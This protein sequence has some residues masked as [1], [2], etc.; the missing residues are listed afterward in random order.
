MEEERQ[1]YEPGVI[2]PPH[3]SAMPDNLL[4]FMDSMGDMDEGQKFIDNFTI[5]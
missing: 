3:G 5:L 2:R 1:R 4:A